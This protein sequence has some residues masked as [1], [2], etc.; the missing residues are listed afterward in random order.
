MAR[1]KGY[2]EEAVV[3]KAMNVFWQNG[4]EATSMQML[5]KE[6]GIN[7]FS[8][9][10]SFGSKHGLFLESIKCYNAKSKIIF[11]KLEKS[12][13]GV[14]GIKQFFYDSINVRKEIGNG[15]GCLVTNT[16]NEF[17]ESDDQLIKDQMKKF[18]ENIKKIFIKK[19][20]ADTGKDKETVLK[21]ANFLLLAKHGLAAACRVNNE[22]E[23]EDYIEMTFQGL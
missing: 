12:S 16:Y 11:E 15:K 5:E 22:K 19:L 6:M 8:I 10:S 17:S 13:N 3:E 18:M 9:Y 14:E 4:Y 2:N 1:K 7:K 23:I 21:Q 20:S